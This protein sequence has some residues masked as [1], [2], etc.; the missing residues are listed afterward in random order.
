[1]ED[2]FL[3][4]ILWNWPQFVGLFVDEILFDEQSQLLLPK[5]IEWLTPTF[6]NVKNYFGKE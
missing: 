5:K 1:M 3:K 6:S 4:P 2:E